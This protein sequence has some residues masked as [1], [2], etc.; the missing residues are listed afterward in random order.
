MRYSTRILQ[1][2][3]LS[4]GEIA[5]YT[6]GLRLGPS[7]ASEIAKQTKQG[8]TLVYHLLESLIEKGLTS[9]VGKHSK[10][11]IMEPPHTLKHL[12]ERKRKELSLV[13]EQLAQAAVELESLYT[14]ATKPSRI[15]LYEGIEGMKTVAEEM[16]N[17]TEKQLYVLAPIEHI[18]ALFDKTYLQYWFT[19]HNKRSIRSKCIWSNL[20]KNPMMNAD[21]RETR[22]V[23]DGLTLST[24]IIVHDN[25]TTVFS[26]PTKTFAFVIESN[27]FSE[28]MKSIF[29]QLW[30]NAQRIPS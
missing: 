22:L 11:F 6:T 2:L 14:P 28:T 30:P 18:Q 12:I 4:E 21:Y 17:T 26:S 29:N 20:S 1:K 3:G 9:A 24:A 25:K 10:K 13:E 7:L 8:R 15:R 27:E 5:V 23:P 16:L 19:E